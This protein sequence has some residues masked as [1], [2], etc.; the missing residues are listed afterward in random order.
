MK[1]YVIQNPIFPIWGSDYWVAGSTMTRNEVVPFPGIVVFMMDELQ[2]VGGK[3][4]IPPAKLTKTS[5]PT[6]GVLAARPSI[7]YNSPQ[8]K[9]KKCLIIHLSSPMRRSPNAVW[10]KSIHP[11][12]RLRRR[13]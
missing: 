2:C 4:T 12:N 11:R 7:A 6:Q 3:V 8:E 1:R 10:E 5:F 13:A 9:E